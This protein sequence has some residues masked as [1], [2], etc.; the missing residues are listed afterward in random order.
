MLPGSPKA[1][2]EDLFT[3]WLALTTLLPHSQPRG[4]FAVSKSHLEPDP[5]SAAF[6]LPLIH[7][8]LFALTK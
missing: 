6:F 4:A 7:A 5:N 3:S 1:D 2:L 8:E